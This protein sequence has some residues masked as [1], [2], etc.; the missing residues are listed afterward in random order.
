MSQVNCYNHTQRLL[1]NKNV[2]I[3]FFVCIFTRTVLQYSHRSERAPLT[4]ISLMVTPLLLATLKP[5]S[6]CL[7]LSVKINVVELLTRA[8]DAGFFKIIYKLHLK[9]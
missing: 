5:K 8:M 9:I 1:R 6:L 3:A 2:V 4:V 7:R